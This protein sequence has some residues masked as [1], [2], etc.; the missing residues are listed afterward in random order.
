MTTT[1]EEVTKDAGGLRHNVH[2]KVEDLT[3]GG[4]G[5]VLLST[6]SNQVGSPWQRF[7]IILSFA[8]TFD[9]ELIVW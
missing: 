6:T 9:L 7:P 2:E 1:K 4:T 8:A 5:R 3:P